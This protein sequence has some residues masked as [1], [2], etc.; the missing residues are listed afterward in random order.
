MSLEFQ[1]LGPV[2]VRSQGNVV[3]LAGPKQR[4]LLLAL[5]LNLNRPVSI[6][7]LVGA[8]WK[9]DP[10]PFAAANI[11]GYAMSLSRLLR[12]MEGVRITSRPTGYQLF[13]SERRVDVARF[14][15]FAAAGRAA[16][17]RG[18]YAIA[19]ALLDEALGL[20]RGPLG[21]GVSCGGA[22]A[23]RMV[24]LE[25]R[26]RSAA[27]ER[28]AAW[29]ALTRR[30]Q[31]AADRR[32]LAGG[33]LSHRHGWAGFVREWSAS[34]GQPWRREGRGHASFKAKRAFPRNF[35]DLGSENGSSRH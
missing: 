1:V 22:L 4:A 23:N 27:E 20:W 15:W 18:D 5:L 12:G 2:T 6:E 21:D 17:S 10:P 28:D 16:M 14:E 32:R 26:R 30:D 7:W 19:A 8:L 24:A 29:A 34:R 13:A 11:R 35:D 25:E 3:R 9:T 33:D 31:G